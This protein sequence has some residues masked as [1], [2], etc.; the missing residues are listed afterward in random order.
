MIGTHLFT[1]GIDALIQPI[2]CLINLSLSDGTFPDNL[3]HTIVTP[4]HNKYSL[5]KDDLSSHRPVY[6]L[7]FISQSLERVIHTRLTSH[8]RTFLSISQFQSAYCKFYSS[9]TALLY[10]Y[11]DLLMSIN[12]KKGMTAL[13]FFLTCLLVI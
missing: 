2:T 9:E 3:R 11:N 12:N 5:P 10:I 1:S 8:L 7:N 13:L 4:L 6:N